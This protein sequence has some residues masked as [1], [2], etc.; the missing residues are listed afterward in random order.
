MLNP[1]VISVPCP[2][3]LQVLLVDYLLFCLNA[4]G[5]HDYVRVFGLPGPTCRPEELLAW[6]AARRHLVR[7]SRYRHNEFE[8][9]P[10]GDGGGCG[11]E[12]D[13]N[14][15]A[16][17]LLRVFNEGALGRITILPDVDEA[18]AAPFFILSP[19]VASSATT[20]KR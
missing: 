9:I 17:H 13:L 10:S 14:A 5:L 12:P 6:V 11:L 2:P 15:A 1:D 18:R 20:K 19:S 7:A 8:A 4:R 16:T 3:L